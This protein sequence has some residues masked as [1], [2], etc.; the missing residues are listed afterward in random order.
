MRPFVFDTAVFLYAVGSEHPYREPCRE[1]LR[2]VEQGVLAGDASVELIQEFAHVRLRRTGD[3]AGSLRDAQSVRRV[4]RLHDLQQRD[5]DLALDLWSRYAMNDLRDAVFAATAL[6]RGIDAIL[7]PDRDF[8]VVQEIERI[9]PADR[10]AV[11]ALA[12][13]L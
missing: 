1:I 12:T 9:D 8:D 2:L 13:S 4:C 6:N 5:L 10:P 7:S 3:L 11:A